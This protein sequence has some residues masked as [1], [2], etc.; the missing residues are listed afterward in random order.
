[1]NMFFLIFSFGNPAKCKVRMDD[2]NQELGERWHLCLQR[3]WCEASLRTLSTTTIGESTA[4]TTHKEVFKV[5]SSN[6]TFL[7]SS[8]ETLKVHAKV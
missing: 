6:G 7:L 4:S 8:K 1:M 2:M 5:G 3:P